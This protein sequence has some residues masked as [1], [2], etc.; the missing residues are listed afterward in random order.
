MD[1]LRAKLQAEKQRLS[2]QLEESKSASSAPPPV[3][4]RKVEQ[5]KA[6]KQE[7][8]KAPTV[9]TSSLSDLLNVKQVGSS[10]AERGQKLRSSQFR[11]LNEQLYTK[12]SEESLQMMAQDPELFD[13]YHAGFDVQV[14]KWSVNPLDQ[15]IEQVKKLPS[16]FV[17]GDF[18]CGQARLAASVEHKVHSFDLVACNESVVACDIANVPLE[19]ASI[20]VAVFC[21][22]L[23]GVN[24]LDFINEAYR[25]LK[26]RFVFTIWGSDELFIH[27]GLQWTVMDS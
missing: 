25:V 3:K 26:P 18:G 4:R 16:K 23:M 22:S 24:F 6:P 19:N 14:Q 9:A 21:L 13:V 1:K 8:P 27:L 17:I 10:S 20:D 12:P 15:M 7:P 2:S 11:W 5:P